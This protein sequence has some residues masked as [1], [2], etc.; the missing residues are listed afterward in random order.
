MPKYS[1]SELAQWSGGQW[2]GAPPDSVEGVATD[3]RALKDGTLYVA[4]KGARFDGHDFVRRAFEAG[5]RA[6]LVREDWP[7]AGPGP[8]LRV[9]DTGA[10]L[11]RMAA[12]YRLALRPQIVA[13]TGSAGKSTVKEL[14]AQVLA[15]SLPTARTRGNWNNEIG[16]PLSVL[17]MGRDTRVGVFEV[18]I[19]HPGEMRPLCD[20]LK[21]T[22]A[23]VTNVGPAHAAFFGSLEAIAEEKAWVLRG[24]PADGVAVLNSDGGHYELLR[25]ASPA[26]V[27]TVALEDR[28]APDYF[29]ATR[30]PRRDEA[31][32]VE[33]ATGERVLLR[34][35]L[36]GAH[37]VSNVMQSVA[38]A[39]GLGVGWDAI[40]AA[41]AGYS[42]L[43]MR[44]EETLVG[45]IVVVNDAYNA[46]PLSMRAAL[47]AFA[48][49]SMQ[50]GKWLL[51][52][53][54]LE[55]GDREQEEHVALGRA[56]A[57]GQWEG[58]IAVGP[59]GEWIARG[60]E[61]GGM[62]RQRVFRCRDNR[63][64][65]GVAAEK[66]PHGDALLL[67]ASRGMRLEEIIEELRQRRRI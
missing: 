42:A 60:A 17:A 27:I 12:G 23:I 1:S 36:P 14:T 40:R 44:W 64:A 9:A 19:S 13:V 22:W 65:A 16:L 18:G 33:R 46:N 6:A 29:C 10:G 34:I 32:I 8:W 49:R 25:R 11:L 45:G 37:Q 38:V 41:L 5:A 43:P 26:R 3:T 53:G 30:D 59:H 56:V 47:R 63:E 67:K 55:L 31:V 52:G 54:M 57:G 2:E 50:G 61:D 62:N 21:P 7:A 51:L 4:L 20:V 15:G 58:L 39:R 35:P 24:L 28:G 48:E 66:V